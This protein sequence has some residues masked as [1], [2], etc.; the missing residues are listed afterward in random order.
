MT[1]NDA[2]IERTSALLRLVFPKAR[3]L[4]PRYLRWQYRDN[5]DGRAVGCNAYLGDELVGSMAALPLVGRLD[6]EERP[7]MFMVNGAVHPDHRGRR[8]QSNIS[9]AMFEEAAAQGYAFIFGTGNKYSTGPLLTRFKLVKQLEARV[10]VGVPRCK[11]AAT[12]L[13][14]DRVWNDAAMRWRT[15]SPERTYSARDAGRGSVVT[16]PSGMPGLD[17]VIY[18]RR[19]RWPSEGLGTSSAPLRLWIGLDPDIDWAR[20]SYVSIPRRLRASP[21]NL[22]FRDLTGG[23]YVPDPERVAFRVADFDIY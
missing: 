4:T 22:V 10:G 12:A 3:H 21:L 9:G 2:E 16:A 11:A 13:S 17:A 14:F 5:P 19:E 15:A 18:D 23:S 20:S 6:G 7:G 8:L 1:L